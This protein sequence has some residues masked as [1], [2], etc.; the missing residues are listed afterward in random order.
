MFRPMPPSLALLVWLVLLLLLLAFDP[1]RVKG[2]SLAIWVPVLW[3]VIVGSRLPAQWLGL[4][5]LRTLPRL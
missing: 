3:M 1:A 5:R 2:T 4:G